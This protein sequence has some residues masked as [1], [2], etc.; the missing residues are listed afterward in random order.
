MAAK[1]KEDDDR[2]PAAKTTVAGMKTLLQISK[3][4]SAPN[5]A[6]KNLMAGK[7]VR[8]GSKK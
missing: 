2:L 7:I 3:D 5:A 8:S 1:L 6:L 4:Q